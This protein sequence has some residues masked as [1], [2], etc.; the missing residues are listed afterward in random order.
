M[1]HI[2]PDGLEM[3]FEIKGRTDAETTLVF[4]NGLSQ[5]T[6]SWIGVAPAF[7]EDFRVVL[8]D[9]IFQGQSSKAN[10]LRTYDEH[11]ADVYDLLSSV[12]LTPDPSP[13]ERG[14]N[15]RGEK[16]SGEGEIKNNRV[17]VCGISY[18]S[19]VAQ[20]LIVNYPSF[21]SGAILLSTFAHATS[22]FNA[23]GESWIIA[24]KAG[25]YSL[26]LDVMLPV[27][28]GKS[29]FE[30]PIIPISMLKEARIARDLDTESLLLLMEG[31]NVRG[32]YRE[33]LKSVRIPVVVVQ[34]EEDFLIPPIIAKEVSDSI[35]DSEFIVLEKV[36]HTLNLEAI[37]QVIQVIKK[38]L[39]SCF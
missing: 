4:L 9:F 27:V 28:L 3:Y 19:A 37:P 21:F 24:L 7:Y 36:G 30:N 23:I 22:H 33:Q 16:K 14:E 13:K 35:P 25:G 10:K 38:F 32:D 12:N 5:S 15:W 26:M 39:V 11:A 6:Q 8:I 18:G 29:Y 20:H 2:L 31:T 34:G 1:I 17:F